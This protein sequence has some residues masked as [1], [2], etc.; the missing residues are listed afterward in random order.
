MPSGAKCS[1]RR[2]SVLERVILLY[3]PAERRCERAGLPL[4]VER[5]VRIL[6]AGARSEH[7]MAALLRISEQMR[8]KILRNDIQAWRE[9]QF[10][11]VQ[12]GICANDVD[13]ELLVA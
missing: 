10:V 9:N 6:H 13:S 4:R 3:T 12:R 11:I 7:E 5:V 2:H 8:G 1:A